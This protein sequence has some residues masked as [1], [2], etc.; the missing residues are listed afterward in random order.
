MKK[1][2]IWGALF[3]EKSYISL[4]RKLRNLSFVGSLAAPLCGKSKEPND[5]IAWVV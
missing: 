2:V 4:K 5:L 3:I 1:R